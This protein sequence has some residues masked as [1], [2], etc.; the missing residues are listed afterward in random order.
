[1]HGHT[2]RCKSARLNVCRVCCKKVNRRNVLQCESSCKKWTHY[3]CLDVPSDVEKDS[4]EG[5]GGIRCPCR[6]CDSSRGSDEPASPASA[7]TCFASG[8]PSPNEISCQTT[9][10]TKCKTTSADLPARASS[11]MCPSCTGKTQRDPPKCEYEGSSSPAP[12]CCPPMR[13]CPTPAECGADE[14]CRVVVG[15]T[16]EMDGLM[17]KLKSVLAYQNKCVH[18]E[19][20]QRRKRKHRTC[21]DSDDCEGIS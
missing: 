8:T 2:S 11:R 21:C 13:T 15:I 7:I 19:C 9:L 16:R 20:R 1:M 5:S 3:N 4:R 14:L 10:P 6:K 17:K 18:D 12:A